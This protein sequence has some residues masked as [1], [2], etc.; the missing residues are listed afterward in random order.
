MTDLAALSLKVDSD[1]VVKAA[2]DLNRFSE[3]A[4]KA[5]KSSGNNSGSIAKLVATV[6]SMNAKLG[7]IVGAVEKLSAAMST[8]AKAA[9]GM[10][11]A[12]DNSARAMAAADAHVK[13]YTQHLAGLASAQQDANAHVKAYRAAMATVPAV[14]GQ[15]DAHV[16]AYRSSLG[17]VADNAKAASTAIKFTAQDSL[18]ASRQLAD[19]GVTAM[20]GMSPFLIAIQQG[21][22]LFDI[23]QNKAAMTGQSIGTVFRAAGVAI[24]AALAPLLPI[25]AAVAAGVGIVAAGFAALTK[26]ANDTS[27]LRKYT[28]EMGYT[29]EE[30]KKLNAVSVTFGDTT[31][32][33]FQVALQSA[34]EAM[35]INTKTMAKTWDKFLDYLATGTRATLAGI[36]AGLAGTKAYL[37]ELSKPGAVLNVLTGNDPDIIKR[38]YGASYDE[39]QKMLDRIV[40]QARKN[41]AARQAEMAK[42]F[43]DAPAA[44]AG[45]K[46]GKSNAEKLSDI[47]AGA[48]ADIASETA[49]AAAVGLSARATAELE[50]RTK[51]LAEIERAKI[52]VT[53]AVRSKVDSLAKAYANLKVATDSAMAVQGVVDGLAKQNDAINDQLALV[54]LYGDA[55]TQARIETEALA[56]ARDAL[57]KGQELSPDQYKSVVDAT[58]PVVRDQNNLDRAT[59][60]AQ[61]AKESADAAYA[62]DLEAK[63]LGLS[64]QA[65][66]AYNYAMAEK[67]RQQQAG[68][69]LSAE[70]LAAIDRAGEAY[71]KQR[72]AIDQ[73]REAMQG[74][75]DTARGFLTDWFEGVRQG[76]NIFKSFGNAVE[77]ALDRLIQKMIE[78]A[79]QQLILNAIVS[80]FGGGGSG[81]T[82]FLM[83]ALGGGGGGMG[84]AKGGAFGTAQ[85]FAQGGAFTNQIVTSPTLFRFAK[86]SKFG[87]MGENGP[88]AV[89]PLSRTSTGKLGVHVAGGGGQAP[90]RMGDIHN[91]YQ[92]SGA[93]D[94]TQIVAM[95]R[96]GGAATYDQV[97]RDLQSLLTE[98]DQ[99]GSVAT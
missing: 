33:V 14:M 30:V 84:F 91:T 57:P 86:G 29:K 47:Y 50:Q 70:E 81:F 94:Q 66:I 49:R 25:I 31:K 28:T 69:T 60:S 3:A 17:K 18:N 98:M 6:Q 58:K 65:L 45:P 42:G 24:W 37:G 93:I 90:I 71:A 32:A 68:I 4:N 75:R 97:K 51:L 16:L 67:I 78:A 8:N 9:S 96:Q 77:K 12:N 72:Y 59:R 85:R 46:G 44:K 52:P 43:Y 2:N 87:E 7:A 39:G 34:A 40:K 53:D 99:N 23:L 80:A 89:M 36:Y 41:A 61:L 38:T 27:G 10:A 82:G 35:G 64:G 95:I 15:A 5:G 63:G 92:V 1:Q 76:E 20:S 54:G 62:M 83:S 79:I 48:Q 11:A 21:P 74:L 73:Q 88:E 13:A 19:I 22:Q 26:Q 55:L 56:R